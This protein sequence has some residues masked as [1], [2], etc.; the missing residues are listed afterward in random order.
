MLQLAQEREK[1]VWLVEG[2]V[3]PEF[4]EVPVQQ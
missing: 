4:S 2:E 1:N 3:L